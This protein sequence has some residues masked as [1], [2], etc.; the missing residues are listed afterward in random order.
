VPVPC[1]IIPDAQRFVDPGA[2]DPAAG[3]ALARTHCQVERVADPAMRT[4]D[5][6]PRLR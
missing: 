4:R 2:G 1:G 6:Q 5:A 3:D